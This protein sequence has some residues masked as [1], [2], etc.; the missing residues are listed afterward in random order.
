LPAPTAI[1]CSLFISSINAYG[2]TDCDIHCHADSGAHDCA[3]LA[4]AAR[5]AQKQWGLLFE[6]LRTAGVD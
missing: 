6:S 3:D 2:S 4:G 1:A 5:C